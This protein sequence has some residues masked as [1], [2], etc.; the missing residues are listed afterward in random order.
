MLPVIRRAECH[1]AVLAV[2]AVPSHR[3]LDYNRP[4]ELL[5]PTSDVQGVQPIDAPSVLERQRDCS[6]W[7]V[8]CQN[9]SK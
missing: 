9:V 4:V 8:A 6:E 2:D 7:H 5:R 3:S 1:H